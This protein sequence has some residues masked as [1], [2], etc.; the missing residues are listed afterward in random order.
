MHERRDARIADRCRDEHHQ[1]SPRPERIAS[2]VEGAGDP[3][4]L[5]GARENG[6]V[7]PPEPLTRRAH[8]GARVVGRAEGGDEMACLPPGVGD[9]TDAHPER[10]LLGATHENP[11]AAS[12]EEERSRLA[13]P[14][15]SSLVP[16]P[17]PATHATFPASGSAMT[18]LI[19]YRWAYL[20]PPW[21]RTARRP[22]VTAKSDKTDKT[23][24][25]TPPAKRGKL[26]AQ[27]TYLT[28]AA[29]FVVGSTWQVE[30]QV[31]GGPAMNPRTEASCS[32][33]VQAFDEA[34]TRGLA[35]AALEHTR[36]KADE[37]F[38]DVVTPSLAAVEKHCVGPDQGAFVAATRLRE[39]AEAN[40][41]AQQSTIAPLRA[42]LLARHN[43]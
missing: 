1:A 20:W 12:G 25:V 42:A 21:P 13:D 8:A 35:H 32:Y 40:V 37:A 11:R 22:A 30:R 14:R 27:V 3:F 28:F 39:T 5:P 26:V 19:S 10:A 41:E 15:E 31:F 7:E 9:L 4:E 2:G 43:P 36:A 6:D 38:E 17:T 23:D 34:I 33:L 16:S 18:P 24:R 29:A